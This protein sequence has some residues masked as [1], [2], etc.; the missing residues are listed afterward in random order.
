MVPD[1]HIYRKVRQEIEELRSIS[2]RLADLTVKKYKRYEFPMK[3]DMCNL[4]LS[5]EQVV[6]LNDQNVAK[7]TEDL[8][9]IFTACEVEEA[10]HFSVL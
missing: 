9:E 2:K 6:T 10:K 5:I 8:K 7:W 3:G 4:I 1:V